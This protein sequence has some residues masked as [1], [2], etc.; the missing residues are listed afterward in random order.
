MSLSQVHK[1]SVLSSMWQNKGTTFHQY[2]N[3]EKRPFSQWQRSSLQTC[4]H[5]IFYEFLRVAF[6]WSSELPL[7]I[8]RHG[9]T[10]NKAECSFHK[11]GW[12]NSFSRPFEV[13][14]Y[15]GILFR[16]GSD[17]QHSK[18]TAQ[19]LGLFHG[20]RFSYS[21]VKSLSSIWETSIHQAFIPYKIHLLPCG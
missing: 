3:A 4:L 15:V 19:D 10:A 12:S 1:C 6:A 11:Y 8:L 21:Q 14:K 9:L 2:H 18:T 7:F 17:S 5:Y 16:W 20:C 13:N